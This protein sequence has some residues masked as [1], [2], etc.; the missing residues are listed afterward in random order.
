M[1]EKLHGAK[2]LK[3][4]NQGQGSSKM[5]R[6]YLK[7]S[8]ASDQ[9]IIKLFIEKKKEPMEL[10]IRRELSSKQ[11][12]KEGS[13]CFPQ[14]NTHPQGAPMGQGHHTEKPGQNLTARKQLDQ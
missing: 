10:G 2:L 4:Q 6:S 7:P 1:E 8:Q 13:P 3:L 14:Y 5:C 9:V 11:P 12:V